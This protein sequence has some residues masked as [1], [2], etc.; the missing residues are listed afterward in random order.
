M[1]SSKAKYA[2]RAVTFLAEKHAEETWALASEIA[3]AQDLP[4]KFLEA[5][6]VELRDRGI[7]D[8]RRGRYGGY[9]LSRPP[10][11]IKVGDVIR[12][13]DGP[14]ALTPC[15]SRTKYGACA[16]C[17]DPVICSLRPV[18]QEARDAVAGVLDNCSLAQLINR[19]RPKRSVVRRIVA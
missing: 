18:L 19:P 14:L 1:L 2:L 9:R 8:S 4:K 15:S 7:V 6:L 17:V 5:I 3:E 12:V 10:D 13:I 11:R 16:D